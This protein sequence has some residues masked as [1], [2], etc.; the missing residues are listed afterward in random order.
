MS[1]L[2]AILALAALL[3]LG[4]LV[5]ALQVDDW[6]RDLTTNVAETTPDAADPLLRSLT[7]ELPPGEM[8]SRVRAAAAAL[9]RWALCADVV[10]DGIRRLEFVRSSRLFRFKDDVT[11]WIDERGVRSTVRARSSSRVGRGDLGQNPRNLRA[12][13]RELRDRLP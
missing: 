2:P 13:M 6:G 8:A 11:V 7:V 5:V 12:L 3:G 9:P 1:L 4:F 10:E